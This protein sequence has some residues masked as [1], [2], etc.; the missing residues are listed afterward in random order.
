MSR[1]ALLEDSLA[2]IR[3]FLD[4]E[5]RVEDPECCLFCIGEIVQEMLGH[6]PGIPPYGDEEE[7]T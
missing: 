6:I 4:H 5:V 1:E 7:L 2:R 3:G